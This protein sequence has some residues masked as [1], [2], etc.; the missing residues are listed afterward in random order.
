MHLDTPIATAKQVE[1]L[2]EAEHHNDDAEKPTHK[3]GSGIWSIP[4]TPV[5]ARTDFW[6]IVE[7]LL[8]ASLALLAVPFL[9]LG[10]L[11]Q[12][13]DGTSVELVSYADGLISAS[14]YV[15]AIGRPRISLELPQFQSGWNMEKLTNIL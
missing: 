9:V 4:P 11:S 10:I 15:S 6:T 5:R 1:P 12:Q 3:H 14:R 7:A 2:L 13:A 8:D